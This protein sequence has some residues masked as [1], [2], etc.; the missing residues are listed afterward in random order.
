MDTELWDFICFIEEF[1]LECKY[2]PSLDEIKEH[3]K[4]SP[5]EASSFILSP[6]FIKNMEARG[7]DINQTYSRAHHSFRKRRSGDAGRLS[8]IQLATISLV[9]NPIDRRSVPEKLKELGVSPQRY[10]G[11]KKNAR[12]WDYLQQRSSELMGEAV[13]EVR[14]VIARRAAMGDM[15]FTKLFLEMTGE[16]TGVENKSQN[17]IKLVVM[18]LVEVVQRHVKDPA[19]LQAIARDFQAITSPQDGSQNP[20]NQSRAIHGQ[21]LNSG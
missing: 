15:R 1:Y 13:P 19:T 18:Q 5:E 4:T 3:N 21:V 9:T 16:F 8:D 10:N 20:L 6:I 7:I 14:E 2:F 11:W 17:D 12:F